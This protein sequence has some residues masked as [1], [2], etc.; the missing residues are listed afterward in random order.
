MTE[1]WTGGC[2]CGA[3]RY[4]FNQKPRGSHICHCRMCQKAFGGFYAPLVGGP[5]ESFEV[6]RGEI[7]M[8][9]SSD[10]V[11]RGFCCNCGTPLSFSYVGGDWMSISIGSLDNPEAFPPKDQHGVDSRLSWVNAIG[12]LPDVLSI[13]VRKP[14]IAAF[15]KATNH[16]HPDHD[17]D[18]WPPGEV[19]R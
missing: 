8:F 11:D 15:I 4:R 6:T 12:G 1:I 19:Q 2:Q 18:H 13:E 14:D 7:T 9:R 10:Q 5:L 3:V 16:Q 17:T